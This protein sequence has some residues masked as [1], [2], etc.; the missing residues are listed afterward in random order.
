ML[1]KNIKDNKLGGVI[2]IKKISILICI[3]LLFISTNAFAGDIPEGIMLGNQEALFI[4]EITSITEDTIIIIPS[5]IMMGSIIEPEV[6]IQ[7]FDNYS[8]TDK[9]PEIGDYIVAVLLDENKIDDEWVFKASSED[10]KSLDLL[11]EKYNMVVRYEEYINDGKY[12]EAQSKID[13][14]QIQLIDSKIVEEEDTS[15]LKKVKEFTGSILESNEKIKSLDFY[16]VRPYLGS[17][18]VYDGE[19]DKEELRDLVDEFKTLIDIEFMQR[20]G[21]DPDHQSLIYM[22][23]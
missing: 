23:I 2:M 15:K 12:F 14:E 7:I 18:L 6:K 3:L 8:G 21:E 4:G 1:Q 22:Y 13:E 10:Y 17:H 9:K 5:T 20:I 11:S 16:F 19:L